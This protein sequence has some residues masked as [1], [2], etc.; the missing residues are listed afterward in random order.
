M[1]WSADTTHQ[2]VLTEAVTIYRPSFLIYF[3]DVVAH[4]HVFNAFRTVS[5]TALSHASHLQEQF[6]FPGVTVHWNILGVP[7]QQKY[8]CRSW[9]PCTETWH[10]WWMPSL[11]AAALL[12]SHT[13]LIYSCHFTWREQRGDFWTQEPVWT[14]ATVYN[15]SISRGCKGK[16][17]MLPIRIEILSFGSFTLN[18]VGS[19]F[20]P[21]IYLPL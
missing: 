5:D 16:A 6:T 9:W 15:G 12:L 20:H 13:V 3:S 21:V 11:A 4:L 14:W 19:G 17:G 18:S 7:N 10:H 2:W 8:I 1:D